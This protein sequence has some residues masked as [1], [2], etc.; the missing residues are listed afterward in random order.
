MQGMSKTRDSRLL[1]IAIAFTLCLAIGITARADALGDLGIRDFQTE[2]RQ[3]LDLYSNG[4]QDRAVRDLVELETGLTESKTA[5]SIK[6]L[7]RAKLHVVRDLLATGNDILVPVALFH[8]QAY[9][10][11]LRRKNSA[12]ATHSRI[13]AMEL[14]EVYAAD[15][16]QNPD[17]V[18]ASNVFTSLAGHLQKY[19]RD[20]DATAL[21]YQAIRL[22]PSNGTA[23]LGVAAIHERHG[24]YRLAIKHLERLIALD[25]D[26][27][28]GRL[29]LGVNLSRAGRLDESADTLRPLLEADQPTWII[30]VAYEEAARVEI[31]RG[32][33]YGAYE[34]LLE[35]VDRFPHDTTL[36][37]QLAYVADRAGTGPD[38]LDLAEALRR[39]N[40][41]S[42]RSPRYIYSQAPFGDLEVLRVELKGETADHLS[43]LSDA[44]SSMPAIGA[45]S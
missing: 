44:L 7:W 31:D 21:Y 19:Y 8:E 40:G 34:M 6:T 20:S 9:L 39:G 10:E 2:Y 22:D 17:L 18:L 5:A 32:D 11:Y 45:G 26:C 33:L 4:E 1:P 23:L 38:D 13:M 30:S 42:S 29:R 41:Q 27:H 3:I 37:I 15:T 14:I 36:P 16:D 28:E 12:L 25:P 43:A 24:D 35:A